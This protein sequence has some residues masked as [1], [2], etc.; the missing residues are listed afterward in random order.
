[1]GVSHPQHPR[2]GLPQSREKEKEKAER[3]PIMNNYI[4]YLFTNRTNG[5]KYFGLSNNFHRRLKEH[6]KAN[7]IIGKA[8]RKYDLKNFRI[9][10]IHSNLT[11]KEASNIEKQLIK[12]HNT[13][14]PNGYNNAEGGFT[15][16][17]YAGKS[18]QELKEIKNK[19]SKAN[20]G[21][22]RT[23]EQRERIAKANKKKKHTQETKDKISKNTKGR[24]AW[25]LGTPHTEKTKEKIRQANT[26]KTVTKETKEK[27]RQASTGKKRPD[28]SEINK[29]RTGKNNPNYGKSMSVEQKEKIRQTNIRT[30]QRKKQEECK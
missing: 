13:I 1:M 28:L 30:K 5:N 3:N 6:K 11:E 9:T 10:V 17:T 14:T 2:W 23:K 16:N 20:K 21:K 18:K 26:N 27:L 29:K 22:K 8:I 12:E 15:G 7:S 19:I 4:V 24:T 25:N